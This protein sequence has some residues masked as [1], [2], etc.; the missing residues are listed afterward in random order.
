ML[1]P[2]LIKFVFVFRIVRRNATVRKWSPSVGKI[3]MV[4]HDEV[5]IML[6]SYMLRAVVNIG[7]KNSIMIDGDDV[8][9]DP[10]LLFQRVITDAQTSDELVSTFKHEQC[11][12]PRALF[13]P[14]LLL[15]DAHKPALADAIWGLIGHDVPDDGSRYVVAGGA[16]IQRIPWSRGSIFE[17]IFHEYTE[18]VKHKY[19]EAIVVLDG[20]D[21]TNT[22]DMP[23]QRWSKGNADTTV[24]FTADT[25]VTMKKEPF[26]ANRISS[27]SFS[28]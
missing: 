11:S 3:C 17:C 28:C 26:L 12:Y 16:V 21:S 4:W 27:V 13:D 1:P 10:L 15:R 20:Y 5:D 25:P 8:Q 24:T 22:K 18:H 2:C 23:H 19:R 9:V 14:P 6:P 7:T